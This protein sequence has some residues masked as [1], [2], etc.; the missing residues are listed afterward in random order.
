MVTMLR[1]MKNCSFSY[2]VREIDLKLNKR[3]T[4]EI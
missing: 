1:R 3:A 4:E 2:W